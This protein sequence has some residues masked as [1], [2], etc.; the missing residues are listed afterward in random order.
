MNK[1]THH[2][3]AKVTAIF[4][5]VIAVIGLI[6]G[7][8]GTCFLVEYD[9]YDTSGEKARKAVFEDI[10]RNYA[11]QVFYN[12]FPAYQINSYDLSEQQEAF[13]P[14]NTN[15]LF[16]LKNAAGNTLL[17]SYSDQEYQFSR[18]YKYDNRT[19]TYDEVNGREVYLKGDTY[20]MDCFVNKTL[21]AQDRYSAAEYWIN[22]A[23]SMR[24]S[25]IAIAVISLISGII[26]FIFLMCS[27]GHRNGENGVIPNG[28]DK[29]PFD[30]FLAAFITV[31]CF[32]FALL[33]E[34][35]HMNST[36]L[37]ILFLAVFA[38]LGI[39][40]TLLLFMSFATRYKLGGWWKNTIVYHVLKFIFKVITNV[41]HIIKYLFEHLRLLWKAII[42]M[43]GLSVLE[44]IV[45][46]ASFNEPDILLTMWM[47]EKIVLFT[48]I[49]FIVISLQRL[50]VGGQKI[51]AGDLNYHI[52][53]KHMFWN[54]KLH[55]ENM[56]SIS[57]GMSKAVDERMKSERFKTELITNVSHDIKT[58]LTSII[59]YVDLIKK[60]NIEDERLKE[61]IDVLDRQSARLKKLIE[62]LVDASKAST[63][64]LPVNMVRTE[65]G[66][67]LTQTVG[68]YE[69]RL[70]DNGL[71]L[72]TKQPEDEVFIMADGRLLWRVFDNL[73]NNICKYSQP[74]TRAYL[75]LE[76]ING[77]AVITFRNISKYALNITS[78]ELLE[79][80]VRGDSSRNT[81][82]SGLGL[83]IA[84]S[85]VE[86]QNGQLDLHIDGD[87][88]KVVLKFDTIH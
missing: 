37:F 35:D 21:T 66:V 31:V 14:E 39:L 75:N 46:A 17:S 59:N 74:L 63:G 58:P 10:T 88:F 61:Y 4:L 28:V 18:T 69:G 65:I 30:V 29:I 62:D 47:F 1:L 72:I 36:I 53:T 52:D 20:T 83:S 54:F 11:S 44:L 40:I 6:G 26:L 76:K 84:R 48:V 33:D 34:V 41:C 70:E 8:V 3:A 24:Y 42:G 82:G 56:N 43:I 73:M 15:F 85:L 64:N 67:L 87:L 79:R 71:E 16:V 19:Y 78:D 81:E 7:T 25:I 49:L 12:Y 57:S 38:I 68:E 2:L 13:S 45:I 27:A 80:F 77:Q 55:A 50:Q 22:Y 9:F 86:L 51:A 32:E 5:F 60:E 23:W